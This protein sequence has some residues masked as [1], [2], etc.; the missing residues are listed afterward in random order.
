[1]STAPA[2]VA[3]HKNV[4]SKTTSYGGSAVPTKSFG[5]TKGKHVPGNPNATEVK[6][7]ASYVPMRARR[8]AKAAGDGSTAGKKDASKE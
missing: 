6:L 1:M 4:Y 5:S 3:E 7:S 8:L 2:A